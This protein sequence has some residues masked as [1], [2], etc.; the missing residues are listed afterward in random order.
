MSENKV[1]NEVLLEAPMLGMR[2]HR[3]N[4]GVLQDARGSFVRY[5]VGGNGGSD[6]IGWTIVDDVAVFTAIETKSEDWREPK[7]GK[8]FAR[9]IEQ[10]NFLNAV[11]KAGGISCM[12]RCVDDVRAA[13]LAYRSNKR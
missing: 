10:Q 7:S 5:G 13:V 2:L 12:A 3:N 9:W 1:R 6:L 11:A 8:E 4:V